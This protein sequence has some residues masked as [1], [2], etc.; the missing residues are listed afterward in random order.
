M[1]K[2][3][4][5]RVKQKYKHKPVDEYPNKVP[6]NPVVSVCVQTY[7]HADYIRN[8]LDGILM[9]KTDFPFEIL[10]GEDESDD[11]TREICLE[12][13]QKHP[14]K[15]RLF[16]HHRE[17]N[18]KIHGRET[19]LF[20]V[21]YN[22]FA[23]TGKYIATCEGDD[24]WTD[25]LKLQKQFD[26]LEENS[27][28]YG[29]ITNRIDRDLIKNT[30]KTTNYPKV[31]D[32]KSILDGKVVPLQTLMFRNEINFEQFQNFRNHAPGDRI[33]GYLISLK[34]QIYCLDEVTAVYNKTGK[35]LWTGFY[36]MNQQILNS[37]SLK[38][39]HDLAGMPEGNK[40][41]FR[42]VIS[43]LH[44]RKN[45]DNNLSDKEIKEQF[46]LSTFQFLYAKARVRLSKIKHRLLVS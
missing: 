30:E 32:T 15:I 2:L 13:A 1:D 43:I 11:G 14:E 5:E 20:N 23:S 16:L 8:C 19:G 3:E 21:M 45:G 28:Y 25:P 9:Q 37:L 18:I 17:N 22:L 33:L 39:F 7:Q 29:C 6:E 38:E 34:G 36:K 41:I 10:L 24:Y 35:G 31:M 42:K 26:F 12:Y 4:F 46:G 27:E 40:H 44:A